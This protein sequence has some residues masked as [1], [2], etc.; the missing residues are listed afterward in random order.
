MP[1][2]GKVAR[3]VFAVVCGGRAVARPVW[4]SGSGAELPVWADPAG[5]HRLSDRAGGA[6][7]EAAGAGGELARLGVEKAAK[8]SR[9]G[10]GEPKAGVA[11]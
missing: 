4:A 1:E 10:A 11:P 2:P 5:L 3:I 8:D 6:R 9:A 7:L